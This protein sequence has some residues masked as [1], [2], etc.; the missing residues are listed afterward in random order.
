MSNVY[1]VHTNTIDVKCVLR[2]MSICPP[3]PFPFFFSFLFFASRL[4]TIVFD[5][6]A[7]WLFSLNT[8]IYGGVFCLNG[9]SHVAAKNFLMVGEVLNDEN[10]GIVRMLKRIPRTESADFSI[11]YSP[12]S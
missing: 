3:A 7:V 9:L 1:R 2:S 8:S 5:L 6:T 10:K 12:P 11:L 4:R